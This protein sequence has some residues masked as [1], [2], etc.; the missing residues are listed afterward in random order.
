MD[1]TKRTLKKDYVEVRNIIL[2]NASACIYT[3][4]VLALHYIMGRQPQSTL[5][6]HRSN[7]YGMPPDAKH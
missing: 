3:L 2:E 5:K 4:F 1:S 6:T 7:T